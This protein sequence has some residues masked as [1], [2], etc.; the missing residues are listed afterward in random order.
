[1]NDSNLETLLRSWTPR[2][3]SAEIHR[4]LFNRKPA[5]PPS[6]PAR[7]QQATWLAPFIA[8][9]A[10]V[11]MWVVAVS[12]REGGE[13]GAP[14]LPTTFGAMVLS[15]VPSSGSGSK[16][17]NARNFV[18]QKS[19]LNLAN[20]ICERVTFDWTNGSRSPLSIHSLPSAKTNYLRH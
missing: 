16:G 13:G 18:I 6:A 12:R 1:M 15:N 7:R 19:Q 10:A 17:S 8:A 3:P 14:F 9:G 2:R 20:N 4:R 11:L 5:L